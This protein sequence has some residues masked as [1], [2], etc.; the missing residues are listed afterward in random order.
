MTKADK[1][2]QDGT[3]GLQQAVAQLK[4]KSALN[5]ILWSFIA[6]PICVL[7]AL[8]FDDPLMRWALLLAGVSPIALLIVSA[9]YLLV[10]DRDKLQSEEYQI[11]KQ[12]IDYMHAYQ[13]G[14]EPETLTIDQLGPNKNAALTE[15]DMVVEVNK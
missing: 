12:R 14:E 10:F 13:L 1:Y 6:I 11:E 9:L 8:A 4:V 5:P 7:M 2:L 15:G 3:S